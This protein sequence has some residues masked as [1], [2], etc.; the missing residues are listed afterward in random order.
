MSIS[1]KCKLFQDVDNIL[2]GT[3]D[4]SLPGRFFFFGGA[5]GGGGELTWLLGGRERDQSS[6]TEKKSITRG[7]WK[8]DSQLI[9][10][11]QG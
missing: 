11:E 5:R 6:P 8:I 7:V 9:S 3:V 4:Y 2:L 10:I 1:N